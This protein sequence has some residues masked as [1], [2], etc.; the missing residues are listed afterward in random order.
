MDLV[1]LMLASVSTTPKTVGDEVLR[2]CEKVVPGQEP[3]FVPVSPVEGAEAHNC[4]INVEK[5]IAANGGEIAYG[6]T[7]WEGKVLWD[8]EFHGCWVPPEGWLGGTVRML[9]VT[10]KPDGERA[11]LFLP[12]PKRQ[13]DGHTPVQNVTVGK[14]DHPAVAQLIAACDEKHKLLM[15][16]WVGPGI[17]IPLPPGSLAQAEAK[18]AQGWIECGKMLA[19]MSE[20][21]PRKSA[22]ARA[23]ERRKKRRK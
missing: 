18:I 23:E 21:P 1:N 22:K 6:W 20:E 11:I 19:Q 3:K 2:F 17:P 15:K 12:D 5:V 8:A 13:W 10:P 7:I 9:D 16:H 4:F 14:Y